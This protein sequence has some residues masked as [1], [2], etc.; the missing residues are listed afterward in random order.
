MMKVGEADAFEQILSLLLIKPLQRQS[1]SCLIMD[2]LYL[3]V[4]SVLYLA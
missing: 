2:V 4:P 3:L 1:I